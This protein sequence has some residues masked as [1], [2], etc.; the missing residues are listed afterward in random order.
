MA[1]DTPEKKSNEAFL[2]TARKRFAAAAEDEKEL[3]AAFVSD[4]KF[5]SPDGD[6]QWD[7]LVKQQRLAAGR[8]AMSFPRCHTFVQQVS[9]QARQQKP[10]IKYAPSLDSNKDTADVIEGIARKIQYDSQAQIAYE[11]AVEYSAG[12]SFGYY[13]IL[14]DYVDYESDDQEI[15]IRAVHDPLTVYGILVPAIFGR[16]PKFWFVVEDVPKEEY[17]AQYPDSDMAGLSWTEAEERAEGWVGSETVRIAE[18]WT[19]EE[20]KVKGQR[21]PKCTIKFCKINGLEVLPDSETTWPG[22]ICNVIPV[23]GKQMIIEGKPR[24]FSVVRPQ[25]AAQQLINYSKSRIAESLSQVLVSPFMA[26][27]GSTEG[28]ESQW[29]TLNT[30]PRAYIPYK[31]YDS[32]GRQIPP[33][34]RESSEAPIQALSAFVAQEVDDMKA[35]TG[36]FDASLGAQGNETSGQAIFRRQQQADMST[37]H[38]M[39]NLERSF[40]QGG[41]VI[42]ELIPKI[43]DAEREITILGADESQKVVT[44]NK[45]YT[46]AS[47]KPKHY[48]ISG[49]KGKYVVTMGKAYSSKRAESFDT[50]AQII[51]TAPQMF[52]MIGDIM[53]RNSDMAGADEAADRLHAMLP[54]AL[55]KNAEDQIPPQAQAQIAQAHQQLALTQQELQKLSMEKQGKVWEAQGRLQQIAAQLQADLQLEDKKLLTQL[56]VAE[57]STKAQNQ[58]QRDQTYADLMSQF[59]E[60]AHD[61]AMQHVQGQQQQQMAAQQAQQQS[62]QSA[63]EAAQQQAAQQAQPEPQQ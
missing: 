42:A 32:Q 40:K 19:V 35:T 54:P 10:Q 45:P 34:T 14:T 33:P 30:V 41:D 59:H 13:R 46:D 53:L 16:K 26:P 27:E 7:P 51:Q 58:Q 15:Q 4:L 24:L 25:K 2:E 57:V 29:K 43:Y 11:T 12:G 21:R 37:M 3:R 50:M 47:G 55:Q 5:A 60:Q 52:P 31:A 61:V 36:I 49:F 18:Y 17:K 63:Q 48:D 6:E 44:V 23:L 62:Q 28:Y 39:D 8:P 38:F 1:E 56:A 22:T 20:T 9:N